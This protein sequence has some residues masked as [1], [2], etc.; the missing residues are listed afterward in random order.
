MKRLPIILIALAL[1]I[2]LA[3][4]ASPTAP[5]TAPTEAA[6]AA[7]EPPPARRSLRLS[8]WTGHARILARRAPALPAY[9]GWGGWVTSAGHVNPPVRYKG[10]LVSDLVGGL[11]PGTGLRLV[12][13]DG[14]AMT[15]SYDQVTKGEFIVYDPATAAETTV[16]DP[17]KVVILYEREGEPLDPEED[18]TLR[19]GLLNSEQLQ[20][21]DGHW[22]SSG[23]QRWR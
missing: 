9:E 13:V 8:E 1:A 6:T 2:G 21:T 17:L 20:I 18:G 14:Y 11:E 23:S 3:A 10:V 7:P 19:M 16:I 5:T 4:C 15:I 22:W 12:A